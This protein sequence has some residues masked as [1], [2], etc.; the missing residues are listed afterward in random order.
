MLSCSFFFFSLTYCLARFYIYRAQFLLHRIFAHLKSHGESNVFSQ[1]NEF[2]I[3]NV[4][5]LISICSG[6]VSYM[7]LRRS[8]LILYHHF[9]LRC[10]ESRHH[11]HHQTANGLQVC[12]H[13]LLKG[14]VYL[15]LR[16]RKAGKRGSRAG[17][18][19]NR[20][21]SYPKRVS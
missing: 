10:A 16:Q 8:S 14:F 6:E 11:I 9:H 12:P 20:K 15:P 7:S 13:G 19:R 4:F 18:K 5:M 2:F 1:I 21:A 17:R 3:F